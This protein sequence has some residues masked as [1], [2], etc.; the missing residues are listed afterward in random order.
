MRDK[1][2]RCE[3]EY[4]EIRGH[5]PWSRNLIRETCNNNMAADNNFSLNK[6]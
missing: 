2:A 5:A 4:C 3:I 1:N 6:D